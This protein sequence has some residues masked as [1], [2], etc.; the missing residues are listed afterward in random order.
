MKYLKNLRMNRERGQALV[1]FSLVGIIFFVVVFGTIDVGRG[2]WNYNTLAQAT[3]EGARY[4]VVHGARC[5]ADTSCTVA[6]ATSVE[7]LVQKNAAGLDN[8]LMNV[9]IEWV[10]RTGLGDCNNVWDHVTVTSQYEYK[11]LSFL[12]GLLSLP[13]VTMTSSSTMEIHY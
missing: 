12:T 10:C 2:V 7:A 1:E 8:S 4:A 13:S 5:D 3:R 9:D 6:D 11:P